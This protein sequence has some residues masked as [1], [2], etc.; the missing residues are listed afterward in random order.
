MA[1]QTTIHQVVNYVQRKIAEA[2]ADGEDILSLLAD[3]QVEFCLQILD[4]GFG[5]SASSNT[6]K[7]NTHSELEQLHVVTGVNSLN[8][9]NQTLLSYF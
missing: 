4:G 2:H 1:T 3:P 5:D 6:Y 9:Q 7:N 8:E